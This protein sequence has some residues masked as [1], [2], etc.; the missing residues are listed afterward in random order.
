[1]ESSPAVVDAFQSL[2]DQVPEGAR[3][4][5]VAKPSD[6]Q[7]ASALRAVDGAQVVNLAARTGNFGL[8]AQIKKGLEGM[9]PDDLVRILT[10]E[11]EHGKSAF[12]AALE[13]STFS[14][15][16]YI[17]LI[18]SFCDRIWDAQQQNREKLW[19][20]IKDGCRSEAYRRIESDARH[21]IELIKAFL[22]DADADNAGAP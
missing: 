10:G 22:M 16:A 13:D 3:L 12:S 11:D 15:S 17:W 18:K 5:F 21:D 2:V 7:V 4:Q 19:S 6:E 14:A 9:S 1:M 8:M 20:S